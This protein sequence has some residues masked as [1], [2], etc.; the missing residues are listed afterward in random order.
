M[1]SGHYAIVCRNPCEGEG[2][3]SHCLYIDDIMLVRTGKQ[4]IR[5][6]RDSLVK[7]RHAGGWE[8]W[9]PAIS[10]TLLGVWWSRELLDIPSKVKDCIF[11]SLK[12]RK[13]HDAW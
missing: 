3:G 9:G 10:V 12:S 2:D 5:G 11:H 13:R 7:H 6:A 4:G 1:H 8:I